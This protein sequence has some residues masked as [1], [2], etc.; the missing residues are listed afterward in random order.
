MNT[1]LFSLS[2]SFLVSSSPTSHFPLTLR[3]T[4]GY[5]ASVIG[6]TIGQPGCYS[7]FSL[8]LQG[9]PGYAGKTTHV[10]ATANGLF[11]AGGAIGSLFMMWSAEKFGRKRN[12]QLGC[13][14][15]VLGGVLQGGAATLA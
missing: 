15:S 4:Y 8:P 12:I 5:C 9:T 3:Q 6:S 13:F 10:I 2:P 14:L 7:Y 1:P 11:S